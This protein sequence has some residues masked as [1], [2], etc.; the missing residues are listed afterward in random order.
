MSANQ[1]LLSRMNKMIKMPL[2]SLPYWATEKH[3]KY[4]SG[5]SKPVEFL[6]DR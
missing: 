2:F 1:T 6:T 3:G 5:N 4:Y